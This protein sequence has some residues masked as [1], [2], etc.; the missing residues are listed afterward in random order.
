MV[1]AYAVWTG[2]GTVGTVILG[3]D[4]VS[5]AD[6]TQQISLHFHDIA[7]SWMKMT[8]ALTNKPATDSLPGQSVAFLFIYR[9]ALT[10]LIVRI[11][12]NSS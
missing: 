10:N 2:I 12:R 1:T 3:V 7:G 9:F 5:R 11:N 6:E 8:S 4:F